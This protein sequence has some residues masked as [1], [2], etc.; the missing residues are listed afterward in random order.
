M[1]ASASVRNASASRRRSPVR[2]R[3]CPATVGPHGARRPR[4]DEPGRPARR[5]AERSLEVRGGRPPAPSMSRPAPRFRERTGAFR[6][7]RGRPGRRARM[8]RAR[9]LSADRRLD[10]RRLRAR[11][12]C[13]R[14]RRRRPTTTS[15]A[16]AAPTRP[17]L[18]QPNGVDRRRSRRSARPR[19]RSWRSSRLAPSPRRATQ[20]SG[21]CASRC[22]TGNVTGVGLVAKVLQ[23][24]VAAGK[25]PTTFGGRTSCAWLRTHTRDS[26]KIGTAT[27]VR[28]GAGD[29]RARG[30]RARAR[31]GRSPT[32]CSTAQCPVGGW[33]YDA[34]Y[35]PSKRRRQLLERV[36]GRLLHGRHEHHRV[37]G[38]GPRA[39]RTAAATPT[40]RSTSSRAPATPCTTDG[41][42]PRGS[43]PT[44]TPPR[45]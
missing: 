10:R 25:D 7:A 40:I 29:A 35:E 12:R 16:A 43:G 8:N 28:P 22:R 2:S 5:E 17:R 3:R 6:W 41:S 27:G 42:T 18:Q 39:R 44:P 45:S 20:R 14:T 21:T 1:H 15:A 26:G 38:H 11:S 4:A 37:R 30:G 31:S 19:T 24:A 34:P 32:G 13:P 9:R 36:G 33:S 23:A